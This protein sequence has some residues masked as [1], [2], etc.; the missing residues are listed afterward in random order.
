MADEVGKGLPEPKEP[1]V[2]PMGLKYE[3]A[4]GGTDVKALLTLLGAGAICGFC[5]WLAFSFIG[6]SVDL[7]ALAGAVI[8]GLITGG[9]M[10][11]LT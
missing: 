10:Y 5:M 8:G 6:G 9:A 1:E 3:K 11:A 4:E 7:E 2:G